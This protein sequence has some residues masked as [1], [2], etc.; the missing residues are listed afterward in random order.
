MPTFQVVVNP[1]SLSGERTLAQS[2]VVTATNTTDRITS[3]RASVRA[4][5]ATATAWVTAPLNVIGRFPG[6][7]ATQDFPF[8]LKVPA[9]A[10][11]GTYTLLF[12]VIDTE[13]PD[14]HFGTS[15]PLALVVD[16][17]TVV[18]GGKQA[19]KRWW[20]VVVVVVLGVGFLVWK[21]FIDKKGMPD[22]VKQPYTAA[23]ARLDTNKFTITRV[24][25]LADT[26][27]FAR[28][29]VLSQSIP[30]KAKLE[31][32]GNQ[33]RLVV[34][35]SWAVV[36][37][38]VAR[39]VDVAAVTLG[40]DSLVLRIQ[41]DQRL[42][43]NPVPGDGRVT[44]ADPPAGTLVRRGQPIT[45]VV[46]RRRPCVRILSSGCLP[47]T[48]AMAEARDRAAIQLNLETLRKWKQ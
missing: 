25:S 48:N 15:A 8:S 18:D 43:P 23:V 31:A 5:P 44:S 12:D 22:L 17:K 47:Q 26:S 21:V 30:P 41:E 13:L 35:A 11:A 27:S 9:D 4:N 37:A 42:S 10:P 20:I 39:E 19:P 32:K 14:D 46:I 34:Q 33:L 24:D 40:N 16:P 38:V 2:L 29:V 36:P 6:K 3:A 1:A 45:L 7:N 28:G